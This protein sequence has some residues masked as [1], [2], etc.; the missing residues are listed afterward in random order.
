MAAARGASMETVWE[1]LAEHAV[2]VHAAKAFWLRVSAW[3]R[4]IGAGNI[5]QYLPGVQ[6]RGHDTQAVNSK[7]ARWFVVEIFH[8]LGFRRQRTEKG[9]QVFTRRR[10]TPVKTPVIRNHQT[11]ATR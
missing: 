8:L 5:L 9:T 3:L 6:R 10:E 2:I 4:A 1:H 11:S 7:I